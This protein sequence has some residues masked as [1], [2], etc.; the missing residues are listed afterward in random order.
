MTP[1]AVPRTK[2]TTA[3]VRCT[4]KYA[5]GSP[6]S[7]NASP[8]PSFHRFLMKVI[9][10]TQLHTPKASRMDNHEACAHCAKKVRRRLEKYHSETQMVI[11]F[12]EAKG[13]VRRVDG[14]LKPD[15][16]YRAVRA[17]LGLP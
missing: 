7:S 11:P 14:S 6:A 8:L 13:L 3:S 1:M 9:Q 5:V 16:V 2:E 12:Y 15:E 10:M 17:T 4:Q